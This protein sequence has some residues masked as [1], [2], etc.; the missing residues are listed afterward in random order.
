MLLRDSK[1]VV[2]PAKERFRDSHVFA[3]ARR[4]AIGITNINRLVLVTTRKGA[5]PRELA[6][7]MKGL[8]CLDAIG[9]DGGA[10]A[11]MYYRGQ[12]LCKPGRALT[13]IL[14]VYEDGA[15]AKP[16]PTQAKAAP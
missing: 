13:N 5:T 7:V 3:R 11:A 10:S 2:D 6:V 9:I 4:S 12:T 14:V 15:V 8:R 16:Q 1:I